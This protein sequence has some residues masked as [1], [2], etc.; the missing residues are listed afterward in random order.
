LACLNSIPYNATRAAAT[1]EN[2]AKAMQ[3][4]TFLDIAADP[5]DKKH[6]IAVDILA[7][8][9]SNNNNRF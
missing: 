6:F 7:G 9:K 8:L 5:P 3:V 4:Y 1:L 2:V